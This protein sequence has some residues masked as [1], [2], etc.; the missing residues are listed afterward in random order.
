MTSG[1]HTRG[2]RL[3]LKLLLVDWLFF[4]VRSIAS[5]HL[6]ALVAETHFLDDLH[7]LHTAEDLMLHFE[8]CLHERTVKF[9]QH[10]LDVVPTHHNS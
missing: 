3:L 4:G 10:E 5:K 2:R 6:L 1:D 8:S 7:V 9:C